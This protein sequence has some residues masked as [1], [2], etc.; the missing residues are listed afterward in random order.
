[1]LHLPARQPLSRREALCRM[2]SGFGMLSFASLIGESLAKADATRALYASVQ[3]GSAACS[4]ST[5]IDEPP[6]LVASTAV[7]AKSWM[8]LP[9]APLASV[10]GIASAAVVSM[11]LFVALY[12]QLVQSSAP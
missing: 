11:V 2:G 6:G 7:M 10:R 3:Q 12:A 8:A 9:L 5:L 1:M 4:P